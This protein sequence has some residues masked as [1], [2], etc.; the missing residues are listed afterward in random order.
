[1][2]GVILDGDPKTPKALNDLARHQTILKLLE[3]IRADMVVC[4]IEGWDKMEY[5][6]MI[7]DA[8]NSLG[9]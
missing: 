7:R 2:S 9:K 4:E 8:V 5:I 6:N 1:M 3:D